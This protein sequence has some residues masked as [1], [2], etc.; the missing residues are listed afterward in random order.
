MQLKALR[1]FLCLATITWGAAIPAVFMS[2]DAATAAM[3]GLG[4]GQVS[5]DKMLDYWLRMG[6]GAFGLI[7][8]LFLLPTI[9]PRKFRAFIPWLGLFAMVEG[10]VLLVHGLRLGLGPWPFYGDVAACLVSGIGIVVCWALAR[11]DLYGKADH[12]LV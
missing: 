7:G 4:A 12:S 10:L 9:R 5:Y 11:E 8:G 3:A 6:A 1:L 2:W